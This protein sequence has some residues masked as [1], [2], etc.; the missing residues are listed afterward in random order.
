MIGPGA[1]A[2]LPLELPPNRIRGDRYETTV[3]LYHP[4]GAGGDDPI[5]GLFRDGN[6]ADN[7]YRVSFAFD[8]P[9]RYDIV[10][11]LEQLEIF[12]DCDNVSPG[13]WYVHYTIA[14]VRGDVLVQQQETYWPDRN[15]PID[16]DS[17]STRRLHRILRLTSVDP[18][19]QLVIAV[20]AIDCDADSPF[21]W[22]ISLPQAS[23]A[24]AM[25]VDLGTGPWTIA[26]ANCG[27]EEIWEASGTADNVG[28]QTYIVGP[29]EWQAGFVGRYRRDFQSADCD[30]HPFT[31]TVRVEANLR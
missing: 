28:T 27:G 17:R 25:N 18:E 13:G 23:L 21:S 26:S 12:D 22:G 3:F 20:A 2:V 14:E 16:V 15:N 6:N 19:S 5:R 30:P 8:R 9:R 10:A 7:E 24:H 29:E 1:T 4:F 11:T 31:P